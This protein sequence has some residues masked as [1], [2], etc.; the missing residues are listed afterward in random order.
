MVRGEVAAI[1][2]VEHIGNPTNMPVRIVLT[3]DR[4]AQSKCRLRGRWRLEKQE[5]A[6]NSTAVVIQNYREPWLGRIFNCTRYQG[7]C[8]PPAKL[9]WVALPPGGEPS[10]KRRCRPSFLH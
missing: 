10:R 9:H 8:D 7:G 5:I 2:G 6:S 3:P 1:I 4:L